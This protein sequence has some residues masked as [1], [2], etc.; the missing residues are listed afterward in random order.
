MF[1]TSVPGCVQF[2]ERVRRGRPR[3]RSEPAS[4]LAAAM[5]LDGGGRCV[6]QSQAVG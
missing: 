1:S 3:F 6:N 5:A 2:Y 4:R